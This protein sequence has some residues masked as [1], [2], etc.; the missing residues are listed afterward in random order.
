MGVWGGIRKRV[1]GM[2]PAARAITSSQPRAVAASDDAHDMDEDDGEEDLDDET[3]RR[4][5]GFDENGIPILSGEYD[6]QD[7]SDYESESGEMC[8]RVAAPPGRV[9]E[10]SC[11]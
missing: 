8:Q 6:S 7:D 11:S 1:P 3:A 10:K 2:T 9:P 4:L 5:I